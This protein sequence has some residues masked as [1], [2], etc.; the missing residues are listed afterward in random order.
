MPCVENETPGETKAQ[1]EDLV[2]RV[3]PGWHTAKIKFAVCPN[4]DTRRSG[5]HVR[6]PAVHVNGRG[7]W[8]NAVKLRREP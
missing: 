6:R 5:L 3:L 8:L 1:G 4:H 2:H 7:L